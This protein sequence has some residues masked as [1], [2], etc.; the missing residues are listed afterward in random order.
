MLAKQYKVLE[1]AKSV[2]F[3]CFLVVGCDNQHMQE[4]LEMEGIRDDNLLQILGIMETRVQ[5]YIHNIGSHKARRP[6]VAKNHGQA[7]RIVPPNTKD[8]D[9]ASDD[10][11]D[12]ALPPPHAVV[13][14]M[15]LLWTIEI[16]DLVFDMAAAF[17]QVIW[18]HRHEYTRHMYVESFLPWCCFACKQPLLSL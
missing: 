13:T 14:D 1:M 10:S 17:T 5:Q 8:H 12:D 6:L 2:V 11:D 7:I 18:N 3:R 16:R 9:S 4:K 15:R